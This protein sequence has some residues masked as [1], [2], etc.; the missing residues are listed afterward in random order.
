MGCSQEDG[1]RITITLKWVVKHHTPNYPQNEN[2][3]A[4]PLW[5]QPTSLYR[6]LLLSGHSQQTFTEFT[7]S[8]TRTKSL[9][10]RELNCEISLRFPCLSTFSNWLLGSRRRVLEPP[11]WCLS[12]EQVDE[13]CRKSQCEG[14]IS[15]PEELVVSVRSVSLGYLGSHFRT[16]GLW[17][18]E[19]L[20]QKACN[21]VS[22]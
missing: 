7:C 9:F 15:C 18:S 10:G 5:S 8:D 11:E 19:S 21:R 22:A 1:R 3:G 4:T 17:V 12:E 16:I 6:V 20:P 14:C 2:L 13:S